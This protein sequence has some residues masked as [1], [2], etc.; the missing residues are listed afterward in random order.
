MG[1]RRRRYCSNYWFGWV[2]EVHG[3]PLT[4]REFELAVRRLA[5]SLSPGQDLSGYLGQGVDYAQS[6]LFADGDQVRAIDWRVTAR[7]GKTYVK[8]YEALQRLPVQLLVDTSSSMRTASVSPGKYELA[9]RLAGGLALAALKR[10]S[11][12]GVL[13]C[14]E[15]PLRMPLSSSQ[16]QVF[17]WLHQLRKSVAGAGAQIGERT[18]LA[19]RVTELRSL[20][21][22]RCLVL[23]MSDLH[24]PEAVTAIKRLAVMHDCVVI[25]PQDPAEL[26]V[27]GAGIMRLA[28][29]ETGEDFTASGRGGWKTTEPPGRAL[30]QAGIDHLLLPIDR[31]FIP[32]VRRFLSER[33]RRSHAR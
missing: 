13:G 20:L 14:G 27:A 8:E 2:K 22:C 10:A 23:V 16:G 17:V 19:R 32:V 11:P 18:M 3:Q 25:Q 4:G 33:D 26:S 21:T 30:A 29:S 6:R 1:G 31:P 28:E 5:D 24:D 7:S 9:V 15:M 12:V